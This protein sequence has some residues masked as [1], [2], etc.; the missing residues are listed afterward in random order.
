MNEQLQ[1]RLRTAFDRLNTVAAERAFPRMRALSSELEDAIPHTTNSTRITPATAELFATASV[2]MWLRAVH[3]FLMSASL[4]KASPLWA[5]VSGY[6]S[7]HYSMRAF[8][9]LLG[10]FLLFRRRTIVRWSLDDGHHVCSFTSHGGRQTEHKLYWNWVKHDGHFD[11][12]PMFCEY[13]LSADASDARHRGWANYSDHLFAYCPSFH[14]LTRKELRERIQLI[15]RIEFQ[16]PP[17]PDIN[18]FIDLESVQ[19]VAYHRIVRYRQFLDE[20]LGGANRFWKV[21]RNPK[22]VS[23]LINFQLT[24]PRG[25]SALSQ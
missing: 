1:V 8:A 22:F 14:V 3:T 18:R 13:D 4:T 19:I 25:L 20:A 2:D 21:H 11:T 9:H 23:G 15:S 12:D 5:S 17:I 10:Y 16:D 7:S 24:E 6:F